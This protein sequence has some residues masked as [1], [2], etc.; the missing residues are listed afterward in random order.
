MSSAARAFHAAPERIASC[1]RTNSR[2]VLAAATFPGR[3][4]GGGI[5]TRS[6]PSSTGSALRLAA[7]PF[8]ASR[9]PGSGMRTV[10]RPTPATE[11]TT[12]APMRAS[13]AS[14][15][16]LLAPG[17]R[18][19]SSWVRTISTAPSS[20]IS[21]AATRASSRTTSAIESSADGPAIGVGAGVGAG[22]VR[23]R[24]AAASP[25]APAP[26]AS[27]SAP[28]GAGVSSAARAAS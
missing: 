23:V 22:R 27:G 12:R 19:S 15:A 7:S 28:G 16:A 18:S 25:T 1:G 2:S 14:K 17:A 6:A 5:A 26:A 3:S 4:S 24:E 20:E 21:P 8:S 9:L 10:G 11:D 13:S